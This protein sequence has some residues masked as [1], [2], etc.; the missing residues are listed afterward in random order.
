M[1]LYK[2]RN[3]KI[4]PWEGKLFL[5]RTTMF[6]KNAHGNMKKSTPKVG[7]L[8]AEF[9]SFQKVSWALPKL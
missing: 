1:S 6:K 8:I 4:S 3:L 7:Y 2:R 5:V 9:W